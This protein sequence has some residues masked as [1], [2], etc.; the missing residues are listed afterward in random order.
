MAILGIDFGSDTI[1]VVEM[2]KGGGGYRLLN[3]GITPTPPDSIVDGD[4]RDP[5]MVGEALAQLLKLRKI[6][7]GPAVSSVQGQKSTVIRIIEMPRMDKKELAGSMGFEIER[8]IPF[9]ASEVIMDYQ[10]VDRP[11]EAPDSP[12]MEVLFAAVQADAVHDQVQAL[13]GAKVKPK[14]IDVQPLALINALLGVQG[15]G[16][17]V[18]E[19]VAIVNLGAST[20]ELCIVRDGVLHFPRTIPLAGR[21]VTQRLS[22][23]MGVSELQA[24]RLKW[25]HGNVRPLPPGSQPAVAVAP[26]PEEVKPVVGDDLGFGDVFD[27]EPGD[28]SDVG[29]GGSGTGHSAGFTFEDSDDGSGEV[30][31]H[32]DDEDSPSSVFELSD[33]DDDSSDD[34]FHFSDEDTSHSLSPAP[35]DEDEADAPVPDEEDAGMFS[36]GET[37]EE[38]GD[39][40]G[41]SFSFGETG[42]ATEAAA[43]TTDQGTEDFVFGFGDDA[44]P[45][46][47]A[48]A[49]ES[50]GFDFEL[51][52]DSD[53]SSMSSTSSGTD[54][55]LGT[56]IGSSFDL[57]DL[58]TSDEGGLDFD[59]GDLSDDSVGTAGGGVDFDVS[60][61]DDAPVHRAAPPP[62]GDEASQV[63]QVIEP[64]VAEIAEEL[65][66]SLDYYRSRFEGSV[67]DRVLLVG[68]TSRIEGLSEYLEA[69]LGIREVDYGDPLAH[70]TIANK[71]LNDDD[72]R[73]DAPVL[74]VAVG[75]ALRE[76]M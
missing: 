28:E 67:I 68:G 54:S 26:E 43:E 23:G 45:A 40:G 22:E 63:R 42:E 37:D 33:D 65:G 6:K 27:S 10:V 31:V 3:Y 1:K 75:L 29:F 8:H 76:L 18:G 4:V 30:Q 19:T 16:A 48:A 39:E 14:A 12:N 44:A 32:T 24:E 70:L 49:T 61:E 64:V 2:A 52:D 13:Q 38:E 15:V 71:Q 41:L 59:L 66:R 25:E 5:E 17:A 53:T 58:A 73:R 11:G 72:L 20:T 56:D 60:D 55:S 36:F 47:E 62:A 50:T 46:D 74:A 7:P 57:G 34:L 69:Q 21:S 51:T 35:D 9:A